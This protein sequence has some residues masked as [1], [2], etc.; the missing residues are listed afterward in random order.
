MIFSRLLDMLR[1][2]SGPQDL[3]AGRGLAVLLAVLYLGQG[4][5][6]DLVLGESD[7]APRSIV[8]I[9]LQFVVITALLNARRLS[10]R[11]PQT[12]SALSGTGFILGLASILVL[13]QVNPDVQQPGLALAF[14]G[15]FLWSLAVDGHIYRHALSITMS[16]GV[17]IAVLIFAANYVVLRAIFG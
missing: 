4:F 14:F 17:L 5:I 7:A 10:P 9:A 3:P 12:I 16:L 6:A 8:A 2:R 1:L 13:A 15:L 11:I